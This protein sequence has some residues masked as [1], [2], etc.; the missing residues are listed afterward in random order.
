MVPCDSH[1]ST[2]TRRPQPTDL[3]P[4][5]AVLSWSQQ[6]PVVEHVQLSAT[7][8]DTGYLPAVGAP[9]DRSTASTRVLAQIPCVRCYHA[10]ARPRQC[11]A[12]RHIDPQPQSAHL[13]KS[14]S[15]C[16]PLRSHH[17]PNRLEP[18][19][20]DRAALAVPLRRCTP[21]FP[22]YVCVNPE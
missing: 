15:A 6:I 16:W 9:R 8:Q 1:V 12:V 22:A 17:M 7:S 10:Q 2:S 3:Q 5:R 4:E 20:P 19:A 11:R 14:D 18:A 13:T 21:A